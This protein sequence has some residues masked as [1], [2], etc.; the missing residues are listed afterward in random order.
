MLARVKE[1]GGTVSQDKQDMGAMVGW[2]AF[3]MD[4]EGNR[5]GLQQQSS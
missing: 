5:I 4:S 2:I 1:A 3:I